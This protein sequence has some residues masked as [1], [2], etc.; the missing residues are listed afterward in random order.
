MMRRSFQSP[1][2]STRL[3]KGNYCP[4]NS[5]TDFIQV[6]PSRA[7]TRSAFHHSSDICR[8]RQAYGSNSSDSDCLICDD[9]KRPPFT[10]PKYQHQQHQ[11]RAKGYHRSPPNCSFMEVKGFLYRFGDC[12]AFDSNTDDLDTSISESPS[13]S[14]PPHSPPSAYEK[15]LRPFKTRNHRVSPTL[16]F[17]DDPRCRPRVLNR[18]YGCRSLDTPIVS[19]ATHSSYDTKEGQAKN[20][21]KL[22]AAKIISEDQSSGVASSTIP[23]RPDDSVLSQASN[24]SQPVSHFHDMVMPLVS[25][26]TVSSHPQIG[27]Y[28]PLKKSFTDG[29]WY[30]CSTP[31]PFKLSV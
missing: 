17:Q 8:Q 15:P 11:D 21:E 20:D 4:K 3:E 5:G 6:V 18:T 14:I 22:R 31:N 1:V 13:R 27:D 19:R 16:S 10:E 23:A 28:D 7:V 30:V 29:D 26:I 25:P 2:G 24:R 9:T 12:F